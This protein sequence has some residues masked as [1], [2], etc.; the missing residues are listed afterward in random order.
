MVRS[1]EKHPTMATQT[2]LEGAK[3][4]SGQ[5]YGHTH[6]VLSRAD[7]EHLLSGGYLTV[8][9][10]YG[11]YTGSIKMTDPQAEAVDVGGA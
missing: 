8:E 11:E 4:F 10:A 6:M 5:A 3:A 7:L 2:D 1:D 9:L